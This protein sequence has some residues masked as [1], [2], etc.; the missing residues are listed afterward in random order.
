MRG[1]DTT[2][3]LRA[4][5]SYDLLSIISKYCHS[6]I[7]NTDILEVMMYIHKYYVDSYCDIFIVD[8][9]NHQA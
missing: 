7:Y 6:I 8:V 5:I 1:G 9:C 3:N 2:V 4:I